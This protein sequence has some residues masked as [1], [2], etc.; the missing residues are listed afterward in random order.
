MAIDVERLRDV[1][2]LLRAGGGPD[3]A[4]DMDDRYADWLEQLADDV[5]EGTREL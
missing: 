4:A 1:A 3:F 2:E 5:E